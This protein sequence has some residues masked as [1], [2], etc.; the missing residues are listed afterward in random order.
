[1]DWPDAFWHLVNFILPAAFVAVVGSYFSRFFKS[2]QHL[3]LAFT[4]QVAINFIV[5]LSVLLIGL[6]I[7]GRDGKMLTYLSMVLASATVQWFLTGGW[8]K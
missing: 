8:R 4:A 5:C 1:M 2:S 6:V 3:A 7:T